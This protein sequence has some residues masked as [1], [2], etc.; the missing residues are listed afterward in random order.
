MRTI[1][2]N[3]CNEG[4]VSSIESVHDCV[5]NVTVCI[6]TKFVS[7]VEKRIEAAAVSS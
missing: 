6:E 5:G 1:V 2:N 4:V 7:F 3:S